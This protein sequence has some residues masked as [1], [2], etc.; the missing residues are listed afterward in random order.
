ME[1]RGDKTSLRGSYTWSDYYGNFDQDNST[2]ANDDNIFIGSSF[3]GDAAGR[4]L[5]NFREGTLRGDRPALFKLSG[6]HELGWNA[7]VGLFAVFQSGQPWEEWSFEPYRAL[8][9]S[10]SETSRFAEPAGSR[11]S[12]SHW[13]VDLNY[14]QNFR[15]KERVTLQL[16]GDLFNVFNEQTGY[17]LEP[18]RSNPLFGVARTFYDPRRL[19]LMARLL[20]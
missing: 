19:Q 11:R 17:N 2:V 20:F 1:W 14:T 7:S 3:I 18:R 15:F 5:W 10:T 6:F 16:T 12:D 9:T 13:Q 4:Q 8:T